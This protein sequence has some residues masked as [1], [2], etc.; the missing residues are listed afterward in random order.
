MRIRYFF[1]ITALWACHLFLA[2]PLVTSQL[3]APTFVASPFDEAEIRAQ[4]QQLSGDLYTLTGTAEIHYG[5]WV[6]TADEITYNKATGDAK[7]QGHV[8][9]WGGNHDEYVQASRAEYNVRLE[10]GKFYDVSGSIGL[11]TGASRAALSSDTPFLFTGKLLEKTGPNHFI[12]H[13][14][15]V[16]T[17]ELPHPNWLFS[18]Q[19]VIVEVGGDARLYHSTFKIRGVP[20]LYFP[21]ATHPVKPY[22]RES[23]FLVPNIGHSNLKGTVFGDSYY[24][25]IN[26]SADLT[27]GAQ[28]FSR[29][30]WSQ[31]LDFRMRPSLTSY[32]DLSFYGVLDRG[33]LK[34]DSTGAVTTVDEGGQDVRLAAES[35]FPLD[36]RGVANI[37]YLSSYLFRVVFGEVYNQV[38][39]SEVKSIA[40]LSRNS[41]AFSYN[42]LV[43]RYQNFQSTTPGDVVTIHHAPSVQI[44]SVDQH[45]GRS[46]FVWSFDAAADGLARSEP[47]F[48]TATLLGRFDLSPRI[49]LPL[50][51]KGW[52]LRPE[53]TLRDTLYT[54][55]FIPSTTGTD[56]GAAISNLVNRKA[57]EGSVELLPP[58][59]ERIFGSGAGARKLKHVIEPALR[60]A[61]HP[62]QHPRGRVRARPASLRQGSNR[63]ARGLPAPDHRSHRPPRRNRARLD[64]TLGA[65][66]RQYLSQNSGN[67]RNHPLGTGAEVLP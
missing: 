51:W 13:H 14:G 6:L 3:P 49:S 8:T 57:L 44:G 9:L 58:P 2:P 18:S 39:N 22:P 25:A 7:A 35:R 17:C 19:R 61:R 54:Q 28:Y 37:E 59:L 15:T 26:R 50:Q 12:V 24:W 55:E 34:T 27:V 31:N 30:G 60:L 48:R 40:F 20:V 16:T 1:V 23:G 42:A 33:A 32:I 56:P 66:A 65:P 11:R 52:D 4:K 36:F 29:R 21:I 53:L 64:N 38:V 62:Q 45:L 5:D 46:P 47:S 41:G 43:Q 63:Q 67:P 10:S